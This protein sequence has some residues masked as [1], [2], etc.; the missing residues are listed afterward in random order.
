MVSLTSTPADLIQCETYLMKNFRRSLLTSETLIAEY[1]DTPERRY[2]LPK[3]RSE[4][5][6]AATGI[7]R[8][9]KDPDAIRST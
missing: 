3:D 8:D 4:R 2:V 1:C 6:P 7:I 9:M 5:E